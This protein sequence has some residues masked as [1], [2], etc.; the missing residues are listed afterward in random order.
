MALS[1]SNAWYEAVTKDGAQ[2][3]FLIEI[4]DGTNT[5]KCLSGSMDSGSDLFDRDL[6]PVGADMLDPVGYTLDPV[7]RE[8]QIS[9]LFI[10]F[11]WEYLNPILVNNR[12]KGQRCIVHI[13][14]KELDEAD[15]VDFFTGPIDE[16]LPDDD[17]KLIR[18]SV[19]D[20]FTVLQNTKIMGHWVNKHPL[21]ILYDGAGLG[22]LERCDLAAAL[23]DTTSLDPS[24]AAH[25]EI[26]HFV[27]SRGGED[28]THWVGVNEPTSAW[29]L[30][31]EVCQLLNGHFV[32]DEAGALTFVRF[33][34][35]ASTVDDWTEDDILPGS[36]V[37][38]S[39]D[40]NI[41][42]RLV[43]RFGN[44]Q[45]N[46]NKAQRVYQADDTDSQ[47]TYKYPGQTERILGPAPF[48]TR[49]LDGGMMLLFEN[50]TN[51]QT[52]LRLFCGNVHA[53]SGA[54][55][56][57]PAWAA[58]DADHPVYLMLCSD[59]IPGLDNIEIVKCETITGNQGVTDVTILDPDTG[60]RQETHYDDLTFTNVT[61]AQLGTSATAHYGQLDTTRECS[62]V[63]DITI[64]VHLFDSLLQRFKN[65][66][67]IVQLDTLLTKYEYQIGDL[68]TLTTDKFIA[69]GYD[70]ITSAVK[71]EIVGKEAILFDG[72][73]RIRWT[74]A[75]AVN[76]ALTRTVT[77]RM[78]VSFG[79]DG[80]I[81]HGSENKGATQPHV[82]WGLDIT[83]DGGLLFTVEAGAARWNDIRKT[84]KA[85]K[86][87]TAYAT[88][89][90][91]V[92]MDLRTGSLM[93]APVA[94]SGAAPPLLDS[95][96]LL[97]IVT[98]DA[99]DIT[100]LVTDPND[101]PIS[102]FTK[103][104]DGNL[105]DV[106]D[107]ATWLKVAGVTGSNQCDTAS[108]GLNVIGIEQGMNETL[109]RNHNFDFSIFS[110]G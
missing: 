78:P 59:H 83:D 21:E 31:S 56:G 102:D 53:C 39:L 66:C 99:A 10:D 54:N 52:N 69:F 60:T 49:W 11:Q 26:G 61:R 32:A 89:D 88:R 85:D 28:N 75:F 110:L 17:N 68:V 38:E 106:D 79:R 93:I 80:V 101:Q 107:G 57:F 7:T 84:R 44:T 91:Y 64:L 18:V 37:Q 109:S 70:G 100:A 19:L 72:Q 24:D 62:I 27:L 82:L 20:A 29:E 6:I 43:M 81:W 22:I 67:P 90:N 45:E 40:E 16:I 50:I 51:V 104:Q 8:T 98:T 33:N 41:I 103:V 5:W 76:T 30:A 63:Y 96:L 105:D 97:G 42:N 95:S 25:D 1:P 48:Y 36:F 71:W 35:D 34:A 4:Y 92:I 108:I 46:Q 13:G 2:I 77:P 55:Y 86:Q 65:G 9:E 73:P 94:V 58:V 47:D 3:R 14:A 15:F 74:L 87:F 23:I 12:I